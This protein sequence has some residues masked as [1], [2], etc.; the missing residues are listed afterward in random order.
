MAHTPN[1]GDSKDSAS[2]TFKSPQK[3]G[4]SPT[5]SSRTPEAPKAPQ[6]GLN[7]LQKAKMKDF[8]D[9][10]DNIRLPQP[11]VYLGKT[12]NS[13]FIQEVNGAVEEEYNSGPNRK[14]Y[15]K[16]VTALCAA[17]CTQIGDVSRPPAID[18][19]SRMEWRSL[20]LDMPQADRDFIMYSVYRLSEGNRLDLKETICPNDACKSKG[21]TVNLDEQNVRFYDRPVEPFNVVLS[22]GYK[23]PTSGKIFNN[24]TMT[25]PNG[26]TQEASIEVVGI[27]EVKAEFRTLTACVSLFTTETGTERLA[28]NEDVVRALSK[29]DRK[30]MLGAISDR[31]P[32][33]D[34]IA[35]MECHCGQK[36]YA[37]ASVADFFLS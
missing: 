3:A 37:I 2:L 35:E 8:L 29:G 13:V 15:G 12:I 18:S 27:S 26:R 9:S 34:L 20:F 11:F 25:L 10:S 5:P 16:F 6:T 31:T 21:F 23:D 22:K 30:L 7:E 19:K 28:F 24:V 1:K 14:N 36:F 17:C 33:F 4:S 32:G